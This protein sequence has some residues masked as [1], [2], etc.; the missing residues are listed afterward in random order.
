MKYLYVADV[1]L[2]TRLIQNGFH[3]LNQTFDVDQK[4]VW[5]FEYDPNGTLCFDINDTSVRRAC[6]VSDHLTLRF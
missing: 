5:V 3:I 4:P 6:V 1:A 2:A